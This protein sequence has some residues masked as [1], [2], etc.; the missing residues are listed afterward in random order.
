MIMSLV[1]NLIFIIIIFI[2]IFSPVAT[3]FPAGQTPL[4]TRL[5]E[6]RLA[7]ADGATEIDIVINRTLALTGQWKGTTCTVPCDPQ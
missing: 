1:A 6:V 7:V 2:I 5:Q 3:G 4:E